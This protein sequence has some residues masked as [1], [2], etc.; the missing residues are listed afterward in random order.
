MQ[1]AAIEHSVAQGW[2]LERYT[3]LGQG[4]E[5]MNKSHAIALW[6]PMRMNARRATKVVV[7]ATKPRSAATQTPH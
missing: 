1:E 5:P 7:R 6:G 2:P 4:R 3:A